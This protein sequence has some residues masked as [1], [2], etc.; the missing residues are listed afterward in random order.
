[1]ITESLH[2]I[3]LNLKSRSKIVTKFFH[4]EVKSGNR[5]FIW[6]YK[7]ILKGL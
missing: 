2:I 1:M 4:F 6:L 7:A 5:N 3:K